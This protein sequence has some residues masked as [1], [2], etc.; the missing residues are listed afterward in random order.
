MENDSQMTLKYI[1]DK[2]VQDHHCLVR[3]TVGTRL[4][5]ARRVCLLVVCEENENERESVVYE[6]AT[7]EKSNAPAFLKFEMRS[8]SYI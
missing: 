8:G 4:V 1:N 3:D 7:P 6:A 5:D 2:W